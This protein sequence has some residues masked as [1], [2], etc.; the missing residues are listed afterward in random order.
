MSCA[1]APACG[2]R[3]WG[4]KVRV[5]A[6]VEAWAARLNASVRSTWRS[7]PASREASRMLGKVGFGIARPTLDRIPG[8]LRRAATD[9]QGRCRRSNVGQEAKAPDRRT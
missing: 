5:G 7:G 8:A 2:R 1:A 9:M 6:A 3:A 4:P